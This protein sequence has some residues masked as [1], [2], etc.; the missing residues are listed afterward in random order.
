MRVVLDRRR[1]CLLLKIV[2]ISDVICFHYVCGITI[3]FPMIR[4]NNRQ[5]KQNCQKETI[6]THMSW[7][8]V[9]TKT[10]K[11]DRCFMKKSK[12]QS[13]QVSDNARI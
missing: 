4:V 6:G 1:M 13:T 12:R 7:T 8:N 2:S 10:A 9:R 5:E 11:I 3:D